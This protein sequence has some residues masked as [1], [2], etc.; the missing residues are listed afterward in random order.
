VTG[1]E[2]TAVFYTCW[3]RKEAY[4]KARG[5]G[6]IGRLQDFEVSCLPGET[7]EIRWAK[8]GAG[9]RS[10]WQIIDAPVGGPAAGA[11]VVERP[12][13]DVHFWAA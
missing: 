13:G 11:C 9:E 8:A 12:T 1:A 3:T 6:L 7:P 10:R 4:L 2:R 5:E